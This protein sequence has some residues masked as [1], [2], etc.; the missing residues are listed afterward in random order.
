MNKQVIEPGINPIM[1]ATNKILTQ[2]SYTS[3]MRYREN[4]KFRM[5]VKWLL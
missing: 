5:I 4:Y 3:Q 2:L 1:F